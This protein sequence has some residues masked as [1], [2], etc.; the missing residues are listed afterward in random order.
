MRFKKMPQF[1]FHIKAILWTRQDRLFMT[2]FCTIVQHSSTSQHYIYV[3]K[4]GSLR[5]ECGL[6]KMFIELTSI[7]R[8]KLKTGHSGHVTSSLNYH[9]PK[10]SF[11]LLTKSAFTLPG[12]MQLLLMMH[13]TIITMDSHLGKREHFRSPRCEQK[14]YTS[15]V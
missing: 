1:M 13:T 5:G 10:W 8:S 3:Y 12:D 9:F 2:E 4:S 11:H 15:T 6:M 7:T 14:K